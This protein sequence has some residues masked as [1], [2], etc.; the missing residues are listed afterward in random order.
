ML[1]LF[2]ILLIPLCQ[3]GEILPLG[4][5]KTGLGFLD[6]PSPVPG[7]LITQPFVPEE[8][9][10]NTDILNR[11]LIE[12]TN[13]TEQ[14]EGMKESVLDALNSNTTLEVINSIIT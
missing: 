5:P 9:R 11:N 4:G 12:F 2:S 8:F 6:R 14:T 3:S 10:W 13:D 7:H 1:I